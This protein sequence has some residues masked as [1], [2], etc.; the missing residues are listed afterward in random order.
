MDPE[1]KIFLTRL[2]DKLEKDKSALGTRLGDGDQEYVKNFAYKVFKSADD[3]DRSGK[4]TKRTAKEFLEASVFFEIFGQFEPLPKEMDDLRKY[5][6]WRA[7]TIG[8]AI[9]NGEPV[10][11]PAG[12]D[13]FSEADQS[14]PSTQNMQN[15]PFK[16][17][18]DLGFQ[19][20]QNLNVP[21]VNQHELPTP[22]PNQN[23]AFNNQQNQN[24][25]Y[26]YQQNQN[27]AYNNQQNQN[28]AF[29]NQQNQNIL[30]IQND[31]GLQLNQ[32]LVPQVSQSP[33]TYQQTFAYSPQA[34]LPQ[35][36]QPTQQ[37]FLYSPQDQIVP[38]ASQTR[39]MPP[40]TASSVQ[41][42]FHHNNGIKNEISNLTGSVFEQISQM[43]FGSRSQNGLKNGENA[44][45][46]TPEQVS[47][48]TQHSRYALS[49]LH[50]DDV[51]TA[52]YN[53]GVALAILT[54]QQH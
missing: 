20:N 3:Q 21:F 47:Q 18:N 52:L 13:E 27:H 45:G 40:S 12:M 5:A 32:N 26:N 43:T 54:G 24:H 8:T 35:T 2:M 50:F 23:H 25:A 19:L 17:Q 37:S 15:T 10:P 9:K 22:Q 16:N 30:K 41:N 11:P 51:P 48:A 7:V 6:K 49:A 28:L 4:A 33:Q 14:L 42:N 31:L 53:V 36:P 39:Y 1:S 38:N 44:S 34:E 46:L 29:N